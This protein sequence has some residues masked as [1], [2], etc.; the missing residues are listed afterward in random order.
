MLAEDGHPGK[1]S[2]TGEGCTGEVGVV[3]GAQMAQRFTASQRVRV[4][5]AGDR[6]P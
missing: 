4:K 6:K 1:S 2:E 3:C 5:S